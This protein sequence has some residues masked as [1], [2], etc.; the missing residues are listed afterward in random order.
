[1]VVDGGPL[2]VPEQTI[3]QLLEQV[4]R[5]F[6]SQGGYAVLEGD[7]LVTQPWPD[8]LKEVHE[9]AAGLMARGV[10]AGDRVA[11]ISDTSRDWCVAAHAIH[12]AGGVLVPVYPTL[13][14]DVVAQILGDSGAG[15]V[16]VEDAEQAAKVDASDVVALR[17]DDG[18]LAALAESGGKA[19][20]K[21]G[22]L[23]QERIASLSA[24]DLSCIVY[25]SG[26]TGVPK[27][28]RL[29][30]RHWTASTMA[31]VSGL[32][33][34][35]LVDPSILA[36]LPMA[37]VAG[38]ASVLALTHIGGTISFSRPDRMAADFPRVR[39]TMLVAVPR[40]YERI[41][42]KIHQALEDASPVKQALF[43]RAEAVA[44]AY[45]SAL[46]GGG[47]PGAGLRLRHALYERLIY[48]KL[49]AR[50]GF[51]RVEVGLTGAAAV[52]PELLYF[53]QG[54]GLNIVE[55]YGMTET[56]GLVTT[57][58]FDRFKAGSVGRPMAGTKIRLDADGE[59]LVAG[60][61]VFD[62][63]WERPEDTAECMVEVD[64]ATWL[65]TG[66]V[67]RLDED[68]FLS[69]IDRKKE[70]EVLDTGKKIAPI[71]VE[72]ILKSESP[73]VEDSVLIGS[74]R[75]YAGLLIQPAYDGLIAWARKQ[76]IGAPDDGLVRRADPTGEV[77]TYEVPPEWLES[78]AIKEVFQRAVDK[79]NERLADFEQVRR[80]R[81]VPAAF[82]VESGELTPTFKKKRKAILAN[83]AASVEALFA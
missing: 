67:G 39:P 31:N 68:G 40:L 46:E 78:A 60:E 36:F 18:A 56:T 11:L 38:F 12:A 57:N 70:L 79:A 64:G 51:D 82:T 58:L 6:P 44:M 24:S 16:L 7:T 59:V 49:R 50:L 21:D 41:V 26:T 75:K 83:H 69:I 65:R 55:A 8:V 10:A 15:L 54:I 43:A 20:A 35:R 63:Y 5:A 47:R 33:L 25:T 72:E 19:L 13:P 29:S 1:M 37:H 71:R 77:R 22:D 34:D 62:G 23:V 9:V 76:G 42:G 80:F 61:M 48:S 74:G 2:Q 45:G 73:L 32:G 3:P 28:A 66:D 4:A 52:R 81:L 14:K 17:I 53:L 30:H 27:G